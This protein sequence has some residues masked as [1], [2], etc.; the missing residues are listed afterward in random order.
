MRYIIPA[1]ILVFLATIACAES[2]LTSDPAGFNATK[3][4]VEL[5][6]G[7]TYTGDTKNNA[8]W[9]DLQPLESGVYNGNA[10]LGSPEWVLT[11]E[12]RT[13]ST[14]TVWS[15]ETPFTLERKGSLLFDGELGLENQ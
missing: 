15:P 14:G 6:N 9:W 13:N 1:L 11:S 3:W 2:H 8:V 4:R 10:S 7:T 5:A 12:G